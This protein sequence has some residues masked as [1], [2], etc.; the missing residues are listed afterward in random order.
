MTTTA[1]FI[2]SFNRG[3]YLRNCLDSV[4][5]ANSLDLPVYIIDD[6]SI[7]PDTIA[8]LRLAEEHAKVVRNDAQDRE[9]KTGGL[10]G[11][12]NRAMQ[13][14]RDEG[15]TL[16]I[17]VQDDMQFVRKITRT[18]LESFDRFFECNPDAIELT[19][20]FDPLRGHDRRGTEMRSEPS[21]VAW[22]RKP[23]FAAPYFVAPGIFHVARFHERLHHFV[24][25]EVA[26]GERCA[27]AGLGRG[28]YRAP[29]MHWLPFPQSY[30][31]GRRALL[32]AA[33][34]L[35]CGAGLH[36]Y[37]FWPDDPRHAEPKNWDDP[38]IVTE[39][40]LSAPSAPRSRYWATAGGVAQITAWGGWRLRVFNVLQ[41]IRRVARPR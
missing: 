17:F 11:N 3:K 21:G 26:N 29:L 22:V 1:I 13:I 5:R 19:I 23:E 37:E 18:D 28:I 8:A 33:V 4:R 31:G 34:E 12:M 38:S 39:K 16:V 15:Y 7:E 35:S 25:G 41:S 2:F 10:Y 32:H 9:F 30:R 27:A 6:N 36:P 20:C 24:P 40:A 14:A